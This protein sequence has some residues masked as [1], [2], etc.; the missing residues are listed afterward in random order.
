[1]RVVLAFLA[2]DRLTLVASSFM[3]SWLYS[4]AS[5]SLM[6][7]TQKGTTLVLYVSVRASGASNRKVDLVTLTFLR[8]SLMVSGWTVSSRMRRSVVT[9]ESWMNLVTSLMLYFS[10]A[11]CSFSPMILNARVCARCMSDMMFAVAAMKMGLP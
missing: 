10:S 9:H 8:V 11:S 7:L 3:V 4:L 1:M 2:M 5:P 6:T